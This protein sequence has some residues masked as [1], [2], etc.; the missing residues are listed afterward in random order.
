M[1]L[2]N[3]RR[4]WLEAAR[5]IIAGRM[6]PRW[7]HLRISGLNLSSVNTI[8]KTGSSAP[9]D[10]LT[11]FT[12]HTTLHLKIAVR[13]R[14]YLTKV[15]ISESISLTELLNTLEECFNEVSQRDTFRSK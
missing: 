1:N 15:I 11:E 3:I 2:Q 8:Q 10:L 13:Q 14:I 12:S 9:T 6:W 4:K 7:L 5:K